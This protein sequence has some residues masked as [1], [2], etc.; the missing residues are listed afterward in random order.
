VTEPYGRAAG[1]PDETFSRRVSALLRAA[2][3]RAQHEIDNPRGAPVRFVPGRGK[4][5]AVLEIGREVRLEL[6]CGVLV[7][8]DLIGFVM[9]E[10]LRISMSADPIEQRVESTSSVCVAPASDL[11]QTITSPPDSI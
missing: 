11:A 9:I 10:K 3:S 7:A 6:A 4:E 5:R 8:D 2:A 1:K